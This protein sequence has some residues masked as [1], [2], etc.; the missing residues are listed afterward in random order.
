MALQWNYKTDLMGEMAIKQ[1]EHEFKNYT[2]LW[3]E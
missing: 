3:Q 2:E 1:K